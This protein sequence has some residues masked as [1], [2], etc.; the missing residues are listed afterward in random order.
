MAAMFKDKMEQLRCRIEDRSELPTLLG[1]VPPQEPNMELAPVSLLN[2]DVKQSTIFQRRANSP[3][4]INP[5]VKAIEIE[6]PGFDAST[7]YGG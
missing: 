4:K 2:L 7:I 5:P 6:I 1:M 3:M